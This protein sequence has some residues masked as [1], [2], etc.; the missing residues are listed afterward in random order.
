MAAGDAIR[1]VPDDQLDGLEGWERLTSEP[2]VRGV[3]ATRLDDPEWPWTVDVWAMEFVR[4]E[5]LEGQ[6]RDRIATALTAVAAVTAV[7]EEDRE[8]WIVAGSP[9]GDELVR[10]VAKVV[11][12][13][14]ERI[15]AHIESLG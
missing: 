13:F 12:E 1:R 6:L 10:A 8:V 2:E 4:E 11:D 9:G 3:G 7:A 15:R 14:A 5:P